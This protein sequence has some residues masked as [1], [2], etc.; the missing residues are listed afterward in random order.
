M[1]THA[2]AAHGGPAGQAEEGMNRG[3]AGMVLFIASEIMLFAGLFAGYF[4]VRNQ[5][6][7]WPPLGTEVQIGKT[8]GAVLTVLL[9][10]SGVVAHF[11]V[12]S[13]RAG[14]RAGLILGIG[15]AI[16]M[17]TVF[18][19]GQSYE[20]F[21]LMDEGLNAKTN[22]YGGTF[23][24]M[25]GFHGAHVIAGLGLLWVVLARAFVNDFTPM[26]HLILDASVLYW[27]FVDIVWVFLYVIL[28]LA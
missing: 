4:Y 12:I 5:A 18:I 26:R 15:L 9:L 13:A 16:V 6:S 23:F 24:V 28:Y 27:H 1:T 17:G 19:A 25:T 7:V 22:V 14:N 21:H 11:G 2:A 20:W 8:L 3:M 10:S